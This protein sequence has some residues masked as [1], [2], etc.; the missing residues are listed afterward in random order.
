MRRAP[1][2]LFAIL[3]LA[4]FGGFAQA[5]TYNPALF[6]QMRWRPIGPLRGGRVRAVSGVPSQP[7]VFYFGAD[8]GGVWKSTDYG[9]SWH[10]I[11]D[12]EPT[13][14]IGA[15]AVSISNPNVIYVGTGESNIR[16][17]QATGMG[18]YK[19][20]D[21]GRTWAY[22]G[23][24]DTQDIAWIAVD[25][26]NPERVFAAALG[27]VYGPNPERGIF[28]SLDGGQTWK[29]VLYV[30]AYTS[31]DQ[32]LLDPA[33][34]D[35]VYAT[36]WQQQQAPWENGQFGGTD[37]GIFKS[38]DGGNTWSKLTKDL[39]QVQQALL[40]IAP[41]D[42]N[43]IYASV[44]S[45][46]GAPDGKVGIYRSNDA[47]A[48]WFKVTNDPRPA[49]RIGGG[50]LPVLAVDPKNPDIVYSN[51][52]VLWK[53][54][55]GG[56][57]WFGFRGAPG[58]DDY[59]QTWINPNNPEIMEVASDQGT[60]VTVNGGKT[61]SSWYN[62]PTAAMYKAGIDPTW[63]YQVCGGQQ[64][65][66]SA[67]VPVRGND[68]ELTAHDWHPAGIEEY[69][70]AAPDPLHPD[71]IY[72]GAR[73]GV[74]LYDRDTGQIADMGPKALSGADYRTLRTMPLMFSPIDPH[75]LYFTSN[76]VWQTDDGGQQWKQISPDLTRKT[77]AVPENVGQY[78]DSKTAQP[79]DRGVVY[80]LAPSP[81]NV[82]LIWAGT[83]DGLIWVTHDG[84]KHWSNVTPPQLKPWW[85]VFSMEA[86]HFDPDTAYAAVNTMWLDQMR[87]HLLRT[88]DGGKTWTE[89][90]KGIAEDA[91]SNVIRE[92][93]VRKGLL[94]AGTE[95][96][97]W[98]SFDNGDHWQSLR[99]NMPA[100]SVR[101]LKIYDDDLIA[102]T[103]G[104]GYYVLDDITPL[105]QI[106]AQVADA[107]VTL[108]KPETAVRV[109][110][111]MNPPTPWRMPALPNPPPGA[112]IDYFLARNT[113][114]P[115]M[116]DILDAHGKLVRHFSSAEPQK[117]LD[118]AKLDVPDWWPRAPMNLSTEAGMHRFVWDMHYPPM[119][120]AMQRLD[121]N[122]AV[123]HNTPLAPSSPWIMPGHYTVKLTVD[124]RSY[125][126][127][128]SV[129]MDPRVKTPRAAL[130]QQ[131]DL[132]MH[133]Y[134]GSIA[135]VEALGQIHHLQ[136][137]IA[138]QEKQHGSS[139][140]L[141]AYSKQL[142]T[143]TGPPLSPFAFFFGYR[144][145]PNLVSTGLS[146]QILMDRMQSADRAP[147]ATDVDALNNT[148]NELKGLMARWN[149]L[150]GQ[151][152]LGSGS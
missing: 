75:R 145:P 128:L 61:W 20:T 132:S 21:A 106:D 140:S 10:P 152:P 13:G 23:L 104:R 37:G 24:K 50:D 138:A 51:T 116:L 49:E 84:G 59:Q 68:G 143:L 83:D 28:R 139:A 113:S 38:T 54:T 34:P 120:G 101:D 95:T 8:D 44:S 118:P 52:P 134:E 121:D 151:A 43:F 92:D 129:R 82:N 66:G 73:S 55:D 105:R 16:P 7:N 110:W 125:T 96:Q 99:L 91:A 74:T 46:P 150:K 3:G 41:N 127:A 135:A 133:A 15:L 131:F 72:G 26:H 35:I 136:Q 112:I 22:I 4:A 81:L 103:H 111:D 124:G 42:P 77:W 30:N 53:S 87:P 115:V 62:Q 18:M 32:V 40:A 57:T 97:T 64:D 80:A 88:E 65:S 5:Q 123:I 114:G 19:S 1:L 58:G 76:V 60:I 31:G 85:R 109:R 102:A 48:S 108:Y 146:L 147:T 148:S 36:L 67:C 2:L 9:N 25:P 130:Q 14:S 29:K 89:I 142:E 98:V 11:F 149:A 78:R 12:K 144:G 45:G 86:S 122:Q 47:G 71:L 94:F 70:S 39:P 141:T 33:N 63:P 100:I 137:Q 27:H 56:K 126:Q 6:S 79:T 119:P 69:G 17:D 90:D 93:P 117:P 107:P